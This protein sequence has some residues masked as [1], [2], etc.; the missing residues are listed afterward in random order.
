M[1]SSHAVSP[2]S[3]WKRPASQR[4]HAA[5][6]VSFATEP[7]AHGVGWEE[8]RPQA[9][10]GVHALQLACATSPVALPNVPSAHASAFALMLP[11]GQ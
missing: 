5:M 8:P 1:H 7:A 11:T 6:R 2:A 3:P 9:W 4:M 10:P